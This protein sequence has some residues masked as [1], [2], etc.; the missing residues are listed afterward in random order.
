MGIRQINFSE[1]NLI[2]DKFEEEYEKYLSK[3]PKS[4]FEHSLMWGRIIKNNFKFEPL[5]FV[6]EQEGEIRGVL[7]LFKA[8]S[9]FGKRLVATPYAVHTEVLA[10]DEKVKN[11]LWLFAKDLA[12]KEGVDYLELREKEENSNCADFKLAES[13]FS[14]KLNLS[15][16]HQEIWKRLP[17]SSVRWGIKK[18]QKSGLTW[19]KGNTDKELDI[20]YRLFLAT[21]KF[22]G[23][24]AYPYSYFKEIIVRF[25]E[26]GQIFITKLNGEAVAV[27]FLIYYNGEVRYFAGGMV[28]RREIM[29]LQ[30]YHLI[31]W[32]AIKEACSN[33][34]HTLNLGGATP[35]ANEG[36]LYGFK[37]KWASEVKAVNSY[38][39]FNGKKEMSGT[40][41]GVMFNVAGKVWKKLPLK[42]ID[43][44]SPVVIRQFV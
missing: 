5:Y 18:A 26:D 4:A 21:R 17:K 34:Y 16:D 39:Y 35:H 2:A 41:E 44:L 40:G 33:G 9:I 8:K 11:E 10:D 30:P 27:I 14:F 25:K 31:L 37:K 6:Y 32:E 38:Y 24:P 13:V 20:F 19:S 36:G 3:N 1:G 29:Q 43:V 7:S 15:E 42:V 12:K 23:V 28:Q 22:R